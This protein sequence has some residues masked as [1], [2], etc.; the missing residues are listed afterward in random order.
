MEIKLNLIEKT[1]DYRKYNMTIRKD[2]RFNPHVSQF[3][4]KKSIDWGWCFNSSDTYNYFPR[5]AILKIEAILR[6]LNSNVRN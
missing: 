2:K 3:Y 1:M 5:E 6:G 4:I